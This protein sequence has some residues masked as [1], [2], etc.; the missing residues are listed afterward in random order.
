MTTMQ[1]YSLYDNSD[2]R[3]NYLAKRFG[4]YVWCLALKHYS[5]RLASG[6]DRNV[7]SSGSECSPLLVLKFSKQARYH[8]ADTAIIMLLNDYTKNDS[9]KCRLAC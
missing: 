6:T 8:G 7:S 3:R 9:A 1:S 5:R 2:A 4:C